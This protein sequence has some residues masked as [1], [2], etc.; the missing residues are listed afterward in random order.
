MEYTTISTTPDWVRGKYGL[1]IIDRLTRFSLLVAIPNK[2]NETVARVI[3]ESII[4]IVGSP[5]MLH[6]GLGMEFENQII[7]QVQLVLGYHNTRPR[8]T[9]H[10]VIRSQNVFILC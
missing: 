9:V 7:H 4:G 2:S 1:S 5:E 3:I 6:Y 10:K 8:P